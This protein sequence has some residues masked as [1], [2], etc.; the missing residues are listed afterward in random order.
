MNS[1][2]RK[3]PRADA[4]ARLEQAPYVGDAVPG[5]LLQD[6]IYLTLAARLAP[7]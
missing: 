1:P 2:L 3:A 4:A 5:D 6:R 7:E